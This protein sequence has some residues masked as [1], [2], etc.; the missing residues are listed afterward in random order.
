MKKYIFFTLLSLGVFFISPNI[1]L[2]QTAPLPGVSQTIR[3]NLEFTGVSAQFSNK[4]RS[5]DIRSIVVRIINTALTLFGIA[6]V[7]L[8]IY[9]GWLWMSAAG[10]QDNI[11]KAKK[12]IQWASIGIA[13]V[14]LSL[15]ASVFIAES[16]LSASGSTIEL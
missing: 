13:I 3:D 12:V 11:D 14:V 6:F 5:T 16:L 15:S 7:I 2:A 9:G 10:N 4:Q 1:T 8:I